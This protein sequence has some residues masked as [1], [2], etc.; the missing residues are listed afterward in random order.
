MLAIP[1]K[2]MCVKMRLPSWHVSSRE[3]ILHRRMHFAGIAKIRDY[4]LGYSS[5]C[6]P[7]GPSC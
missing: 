2:C 6:E 5:V 7:S 4:S 1:A 3:P